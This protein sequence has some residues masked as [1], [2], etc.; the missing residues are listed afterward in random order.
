MTARDAEETCSD[1]EEAR[2]TF[3]LEADATPL[4]SLAH[5][6]GA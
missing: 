3:S 6:A 4:P 2:L 5:G 1:I